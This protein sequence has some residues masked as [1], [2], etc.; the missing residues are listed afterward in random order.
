MNE[1][2]SGQRKGYLHM[3][4]KNSYNEDKMH[5]VSVPVVKGVQLI[6]RKRCLALEDI[7]SNSMTLIHFSRVIKG[8]PHPQRAS[9]TKP[10]LSSSLN[11][12]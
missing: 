7:E 9:S 3:K 2:K 5:K 11:R 12:K 1:Y 8:P 10:P 6:R 4:R